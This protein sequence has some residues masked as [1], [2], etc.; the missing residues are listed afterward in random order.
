MIYDL[1]L[2]LPAL[3]KFKEKYPTW[4]FRIGWCDLTR[5]FSCAPQSHSPEIDYIKYAG[6]VWDSGF[7]CDHEGSLSD[8]IYDVMDQIEAALTN[9]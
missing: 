4:W 5:D 9:N 8:A 7:H 3:Q 1:T 2:D 6:D